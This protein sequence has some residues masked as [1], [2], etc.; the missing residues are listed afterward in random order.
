MAQITVDQEIGSIKK[1]VFK[2]GGLCGETSH[3]RSAIEACRQRAFSQQSKKYDFTL[4]RLHNLFSNQQ[5]YNSLFHN[6]NITN[7]HYCD[8]L[9][10]VSNVV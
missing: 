8:G 7:V 3:M 4:L 1:I 5:E 10:Y 9:L 6:W 2:G